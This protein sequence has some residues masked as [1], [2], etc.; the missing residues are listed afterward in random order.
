MCA[1]VGYYAAKYFAQDGGAIV[2]TICDWD[3]YVRNEDGLD[4]EALKAHHEATGSIAGFP[5]ATTVVCFHD[6]ARV[7]WHVAAWRGM[8]CRRLTWLGT[9][10]Y[11]RQRLS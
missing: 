11:P 6:C 4:I 8:V 9:K 10:I 5:G 7:G 1:L 2:T 3:C